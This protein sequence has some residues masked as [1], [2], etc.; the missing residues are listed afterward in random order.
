MQNAPAPLTDCDQGV[1]CKRVLLVT[2]TAATSG[3]LRSAFQQQR[4]PWQT[5]FV[6]SAAEALAELDR[7]RFHAIVSEL[8]LPQTDGAQLL[9]QV[10]ER[11]PNVV[12]LCLSDGV[13]EELFLRAVPVTHQFLSKPCNADTVREVIECACSVA[14][15]LQNEAIREL[16]GKLQALPAT[17]QTF[18]AL[19]AAIARP[20]AHTADIC[21]IVTND[22]ALCVKTLQ[23]VNSAMFRRTGP[24]TSIQ[25]AV[26]YVGLE[27]LK[28]L[29]LSACM[30]QALDASPA[31][32]KRLADLQARSIRKARLAHLL[33]EGSHG[34]DEAFTAA[35]LLDI[36]QAV[37]ALSAAAQFERMVALSRE[38]DLP[39]HQ[40]EPECFG[41]AHPEVGACLL[42]LWGLPLELIEAVANH[43]CPSRVQHAQTR[44][45]A[46]VH[47]ADAIVDAS[48][49]HPARLLDH[50]D[51]A[52]VARAEVSRYLSDWDI[53]PAADARSLQRTR[54]A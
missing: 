35:L 54:A 27:M 24:I 31:T 9:S 13:D 48:A 34:A 43:H 40:V 16:I 11:H 46:A 45:L 30:F 50:L 33:L 17:P 41:V 32:G 7:A 23:I 39:W 49:D 10:R 8:H 28:S 14:G 19:S 26:A 5:V 53:D 15:L 36:G 6:P 29:A 20:N 1:A 44:V 37:L 38:R 12:R 3:A 25:A 47:V 51:A 52:F 2:G 22:R 4:S 42:G 18:E 21:G